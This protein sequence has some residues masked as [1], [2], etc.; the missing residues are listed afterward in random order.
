MNIRVEP[1]GLVVQFKDIPPEMLQ[2]QLRNYGFRFIRDAGYWLR[3]STRNAQTIVAGL[4]RLAT[5]LEAPEGDFLPSG[6]Q[7]GQNRLPD[8]AAGHATCKETS[9]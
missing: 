2:S 8:A 4:S 3:V 7:S 9:C 6:D 1:F 5:L